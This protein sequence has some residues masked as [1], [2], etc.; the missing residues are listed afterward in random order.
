MNAKDLVNAL[1]SLRRKAKWH[2]EK[3]RIVHLKPVQPSTGSVLLS[4]MIE[5]FLLRKGHQVRSHHTSYWECVRIAETFLD[6]GYSV[7]VINSYNKTFW[8]RKRYDFFI[9]HRTVLERVAEV[10]NHDCIK[11]MHID[12]AHALFNNAAEAQRLLELQR[13]RNVTL[14]P[15]RFMMPNLAIEH[16][17][18]ATVLGNA[19]TMSTFTY[20]GK[21]LYR[22]PISATVLYEWPSDKDFV[23]SRRHFIWLNSGG[24]VHKG[25]DLALEAFAGMPDHRLTVCGP[26]EQEEDFVRVFRK[27]LYDT[28]NIT[29]VGWVDVAGQKF[30]DLARAAVGLVSPSCS[31]G[32]SGSVV[33]GMHAGLVPIVS[34]E[35]GVD[36][37]EDRGIVLPNC[38]VAEIRRS[39]RSISDRPAGELQTLARRSWE[40]ARATYTR[41]KFAES[42]SAAIDAIVQRNRNDVRFSAASDPVRRAAHHPAD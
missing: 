39:V 25:L 24:L 19:F 29:T 16:A 8:P 12:T 15:R 10:L 41:E 18:Y 13:R 21:P 4:Y 20:A 28:P 5:P 30:S 33:T 27:E 42:Y 34:Y 35:S 36:V 2:L 37:S 17:D 7:D 9:E 26:V 6:M 23:A 1:V 3:S 32:C 31:E 22:L 40:Y 14:C 38:S 11:I